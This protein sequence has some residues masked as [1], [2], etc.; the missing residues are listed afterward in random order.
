MTMQL[1][2]HSR[3]NMVKGLAKLKNRLRHGHTAK[4]V[5]ASPF[6]R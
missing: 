5:D 6:W 4:C 2:G 1:P 3:G